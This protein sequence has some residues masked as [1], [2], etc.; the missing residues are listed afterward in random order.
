MRFVTGL[1][2]FAGFCG[3]VLLLQQSEDRIY[4][5]GAVAPSCWERYEGRIH[6]ALEAHPDLTDVGGAWQVSTS[7]SVEGD[8]MF[9]VQWGPTRQSCNA[10]VTVRRNDEDRSSPPFIGDR[11][12]PSSGT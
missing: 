1:V 11:P 10:Y 8:W 7:C 2:M 3:N 12:P 4:L 6:D 9:D 5:V